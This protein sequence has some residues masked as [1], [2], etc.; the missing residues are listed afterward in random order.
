MPQVFK[1]YDP[2]PNLSYQEFNF[3]DEHMPSIN[4]F[5]YFMFLI[6]Y[7]KPNQIFNYV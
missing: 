5:N 7:T 6:Y 1:I 3:C 4:N 2:K